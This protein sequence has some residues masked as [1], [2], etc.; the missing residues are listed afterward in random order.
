MR[1]FAAHLFL[2][3]L[4]LPVVTGCARPANLGMR[5]S[6]TTAITITSQPPGPTSAA[7]RIVPPPDPND[8]EPIWVTNPIDRTLLR[9]DPL[10]DAVVATILIDGQPD[11]A[12]A[13]EGAVWALDRAHNLVFRIDP[14]SNRVVTSIPLP[15]GNSEALAVGA[16]AVWVGMT[17]RIDL[18]EQAPG[19]EEDVLPPAMVVQIDPQTNRFLEP[20][21]VQPIGRLRISGSTLWV[22][23]HAIIDTPLQVIDLNSKQ[24]MAVPLH[25]SPAWLPIDALEVDQGNLWLLSA[26]YGKIFHGTPDGRINASID[27][28]QRQPTGYADLLLTRTGLWAITPWGTVLQIDPSTNHIDGTLDLNMPLTSLISSGGAV[29]VFSQ[30]AATLFRIDPAS[31][32]VTAQISTGSLLQPTVV[33]SPTARVV[34]WK[35]CP[36]APTSRLKVG[37]LAY[38]NKEPPLPNRVRK[39]PNRQADVLGHINPGGSMEILEGPTCADNWVWWHVKNADLNGWMAEGDQETYWMVPLYK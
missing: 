27:V 3:L 20:F 8:N 31:R 33:P 2:I 38:V 22:L 15:A 16:G 23:S 19:Q 13:G 39:E 1:R 10:N 4:F 24:G 17:G 37:D 6:P 35:P 11:I 21:P 14:A 34:I 30:Q 36:D 12:A 18:N 32:V 28:G 7:T 5:V 26:A 9:I 29:W 25:N